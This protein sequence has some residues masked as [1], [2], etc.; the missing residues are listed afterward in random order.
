LPQPFRRDRLTPTFYA[1][2]AANATRRGSLAHNYT[3]LQQ[4]ATARP[5]RLARRRRAH[6]GAGARSPFDAPH[7]PASTRCKIP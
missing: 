6:Y 1:A 5:W 4:A 2:G 3:R 7:N